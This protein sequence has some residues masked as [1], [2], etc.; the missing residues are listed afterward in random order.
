MDHDY[1]SWVI[2]RHL[3]LELLTRLGIWCGLCL[4]VKMPWFFPLGVRNC[5]TYFVY[6]GTYSNSERDLGLFKVLPFLKTVGLL[7]LYYVLYCD[8]STRTWET[9]K[10][11]YVLRVTCLYVKLTQAKV[12]WLMILLGWCKRDM[13]V[14]QKWGGTGKWEKDAS[15]SVWW[16]LEF[17]RTKPSW[18]PISYTLEHAWG[19][20][21]LWQEDIVIRTSREGS[22]KVQWSPSP[23]RER[24]LTV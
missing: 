3:P 23:L 11:A 22:R 15:G 21:K 4:I 14:H 20:M 7:K 13:C 18:F 12:S 24:I 8:I 19:F 1:R 2:P 17:L 9:R 5:L 6:K 16:M 10:K